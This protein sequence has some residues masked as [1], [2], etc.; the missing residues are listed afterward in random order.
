MVS[1]KII[2]GI[3]ILAILIAGCVNRISATEGSS[4]RIKLIAQ[5]FPDPNNRAQ[6]INIYHDDIGKATC[7]SYRVGGIGVGFQCFTDS[8]LKYQKP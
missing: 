6:E 8:E 7:Y 5:T 2:I 4:N 1:K 3:L